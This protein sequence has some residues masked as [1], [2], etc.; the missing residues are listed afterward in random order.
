MP[1]TAVFTPTTR[2]RLSASAPPEL[3]G[4]RAASVWITLSITRAARRERA[5]SERPRADTTPA[6]T[7]PLKPWGLPIATTSWPTRER[8]GV[9]Q[10]GLHEAVAVRADDGEVGELV[11]P[12]DLEAV[13]APVRESRP[14]LARRAA[15]HVGGGEEEAV[16]REHH[17]A[18]GSRR[19]LAPAARAA[20]PAGS[21]P[22]ASGAPP[23][24]SRRASTRRGPRR[25]P[26]PP[27][28][29]RRPRPR[30]C[31][32]LLE[33][34]VDLALLGPAHEGERELGVRRR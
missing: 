18:A 27:A 17:G 20:S 1:A 32:L 34:H 24:P 11:P 29:A 7:E 6:V 4:F 13:L 22:T 31:R 16:G 12:D 30:S 5:G 9:A 15:D 3:P 21:R 10:L 23:R 14:S 19:Q 26:G 28:A 2:P 33:R 8:V 25:R